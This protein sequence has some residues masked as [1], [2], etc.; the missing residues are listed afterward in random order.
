MTNLTEE[1]KRE[2]YEEMKK[3]EEEKENKKIYLNCFRRQ[4]KRHSITFR[5]CY[6]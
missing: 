4:K 2:I 3:A 5:R 6:K 1:Q